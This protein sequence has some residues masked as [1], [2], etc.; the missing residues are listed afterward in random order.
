MTNLELVN[1]YESLTLLN[2]KGVK[3]AYAV[4][5]NINIIKPELKALSDAQKPS[6]LYKEYE[7]ERI[8][9]CKKMASKDEKGK[10]IIEENA[11]KFDDKE[12]FEAELDKLKKKHKEAVE[13]RE[14][15]AKEVEELFS[16]KSKIKLHKIKIDDVP[17]EIS[18]K[19][20][21]S[22]MFII[23]E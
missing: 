4:A 2:L 9:L 20:L 1:L 14:K 15:Q 12:A 10:P 16:M 17:Q 6:E 22:I 3:F 19:E 5:K 11:Y 13:E 23:E 18:T 8:E 7:K 21:S